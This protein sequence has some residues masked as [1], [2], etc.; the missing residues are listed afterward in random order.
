[1]TYRRFGPEVYVLFVQFA[2]PASAAQSRTW[3]DR[4][5]SRLQVLSQFGRRI[6]I[7]SY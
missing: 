3:Q 6:V 5:E 7:S 4:P 2:V 1:M